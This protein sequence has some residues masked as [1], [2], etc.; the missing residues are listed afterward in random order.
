MRCRYQNHE[1]ECN[2]YQFPR[3]NG[4]PVR[5]EDAQCEIEKREQDEHHAAEEALE[6]HK[7]SGYAEMM[8]SRAD[9]M[10]KA[11]RENAL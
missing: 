5:P 3:H 7:R 6:P 8:Y 1:G 10:R 4:L 11:A 2:S 9:D